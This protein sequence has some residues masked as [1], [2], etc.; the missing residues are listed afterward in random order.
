MTNQID[1]D[2]AAKE[3]LRGR[4]ADLAE[5]LDHADLAQ[6][7]WVTLFDELLAADDQLKKMED[8]DLG[9]HVI[10]TDGEVLELDTR[11]VRTITNEIPF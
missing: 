11:P 10:V 3:A 5:E 6:R 8:S 1:M 7:E 2:A 4:I 9:T